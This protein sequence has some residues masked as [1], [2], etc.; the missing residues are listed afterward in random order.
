MIADMMKLVGNAAFGRSG[1]DMSKQK[2]VDC[3]SDEDAIYK[4]TEHFTFSNKTAFRD[5]T[6]EISKSKRRIKLK[7]PVHVSIAIYQLAKL[8]MLQFYYD[9]IDF[10]FERS[11]FQHPEM[12]TDSAY[13][14][15]SDEHPFKILIKHDLIDHFEEHKHEW[16]SRDDTNENADFDRRTPSLFKEEFRCNAMVSL[17]SKNYICYLGDEIDKKTKNPKIKLSA[18]GIQKSKNA[19]VLTPAKF[20]S[21]IK[22]RITIQGNN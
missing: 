12:D 7:N 5:G 13:I 1:M 21:V 9:C 3:L 2:E 19:N 6:A 20:E 4:A 15:F 14:A 8:R 16:F 17:S 11:D 18:K 10:Y 22:D